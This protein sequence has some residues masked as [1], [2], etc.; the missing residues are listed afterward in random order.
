MRPEFSSRLSHSLPP[1]SWASHLIY[2]VL[3]FPTC[4]IGIMPPYLT[5]MLGGYNPLMIVRYGATMMMRGRWVN[6]SANDFIQPYFCH[7]LFIFPSVFRSS[8][9]VHTNICG[10]AV[11]YTTICIHIW[12]TFMHEEAI[13]YPLFVLCYLPLIKKFL[14]KKFQS[15]NQ[16]ME[17][18]S[19]DLCT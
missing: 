6:D 17:T 10:D 12:I 11:H 9:S 18:I 5:G 8:V 14:F 4:K 15:S 16:E 3:Q 7:L 1:L 13:H 19:C 2:P